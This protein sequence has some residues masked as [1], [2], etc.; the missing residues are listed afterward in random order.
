MAVR[1]AAPAPGRAALA[2]P[3]ANRGGTVCGVDLRLK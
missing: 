1:A 2:A 3:Q